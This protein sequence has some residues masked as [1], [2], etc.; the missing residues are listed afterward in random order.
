MWSAL[1]VYFQGIDGWNFGA[2]WSGTRTS[3]TTFTTT[4]AIEGKVKAGDKLKFYD[5]TWKFA[6]IVSIVNVAGTRTV[7]IS[8]DTLVGNPSTFYYSHD[9]L[10]YEFPLAYA[11]GY[12]H[13]HA[14]SG[15][16]SISTISPTTSNVSAAEGTFYIADISGLTANRDFNLPTPSAAGKQIAIKLSTGDNT[17]A[18]ILKING[19]E[20][21]RIFITGEVVKFISTG[22]GASN[23]VVEE[24][25][26]IPCSAILER[27]SAQSVASGSYPVIVQLS[28]EVKDAGDIGN[29]ST[30][31]ITIRRAGIYDIL[32]VV[33]FTN[34]FSTAKNIQALIHLNGSLL[35]YQIT[36]TSH[37]TGAA[38]QPG[39]AR[40]P[41][42]KSLAVGDY[43]ELVAYHNQG[44]AV[45]TGTTTGYPQLS[46]K[47]QLDK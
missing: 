3:D 27:Q 23:W 19:T 14:A 21:S 20:W 35:T 12:G 16:Y 26:R 9:E 46:V 7:T 37:T 44:S 13:T 4:Q 17:Y 43:L 47:E 15:G 8:G 36:Y 29:P 28:T 31:K 22:T 40:C 42:K 25:G 1:S 45:N 32:G 5:S 6:N 24:D 41:T 10:P 39:M 18:L 33:I 2:G 38:D 30:Y 34:S 11:T